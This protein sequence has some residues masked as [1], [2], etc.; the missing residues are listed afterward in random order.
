VQYGSF[1]MNTGAEIWQAIVDAAAGRLGAVPA[2]N[3]AASEGVA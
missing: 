1:V 2:R 3:L